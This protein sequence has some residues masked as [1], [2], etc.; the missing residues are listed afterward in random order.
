MLEPEDIPDL[1]VREWFI[2]RD[3]NIVVA[4]QP[5]E[6]EF[7][8]ETELFG[9]KSSRYPTLVELESTSR[10]NINPPCPM[11]SRVS[12]AFGA[13]PE[14]DMPKELVQWIANCLK[15]TSHVSISGVGEPMLAKTFPDMVKLTA[16]ASIGFF[17]NG[18]VLSDDRMKL[19]L[20]RPVRAI[21]FSLDAATPETF[22][23]LRGVNINDFDRVLGNIRRL[24]EAKKARSQSKPRLEAVFI[25]MKENYK[26]LP[27]FV[28]VCHNIGFD[29]I[30]YRKMCVPSD[31]GDYFNHERHGF[32]FSYE[33]QSSL[34]SDWPD[35]LEKAKK[36]ADKLQM[37]FN[38]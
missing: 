3:K 26:E 19:I 7:E 14:Y 13:T 36:V 6:I 1:A 38:T 18:L 33:E 30:S 4:K 5:K 35:I 37:P 27:E 12:R 11:C 21:A 22:Y 31:P 2:A 25:V 29:N 32:F 9:M 28:R 34:P 24:A 23:K 10:C 17:S 15:Y 16:N 8:E 20:D